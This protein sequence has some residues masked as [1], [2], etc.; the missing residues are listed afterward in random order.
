MDEPR[1]CPPYYR[2]PSTSTTL[3]HTRACIQ[4]CRTLDPTGTRITP[5]ITPR[6]ALS[7][8]PTT[9][10]ALATLAQQEALPIQTHISENAAEI[11]L[12]AELFP[13]ADSYAA[14]YDSA[15][16]LTE[17]TILAHAVHLTEAER[18]LV[19]QRKAK[20][21][22]CPASNSALGSGYCA[23]RTLLEAGIAVGLGTDVSGGYA[24]SVLEAVRQ[25]CLVS[26]TV[27]FQHAE[28][29]G[30][31]DADARFN[32][33]FVEGLQL[34]TVG[35]AE[36]VGMKGRLGD[37]GVGMLWDVQEIDLRG[38][39]GEGGGMEDLT[40][41][42]AGPVDLFGWETWEEEVAKWVWNGDDRNVRRV[43]VG[44]QLVHEKKGSSP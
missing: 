38:G 21:A 16:L 18:A 8:L 35:G 42:A 36:V 13:R 25:A 34:A 44:G 30:G 3:T 6:F 43:W 39:G 28:A 5:I 23:V 20:V 24:V 1:T 29:P 26:R 37:F 27:A 22:H 11:A 4:H 7:C 15:G 2:D 17:R 10:T 12:V 41:A 9:L 32:I 33:G 31:G 19:S 14:V 40:T